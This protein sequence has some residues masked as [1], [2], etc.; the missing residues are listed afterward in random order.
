MRNHTCLLDHRQKI[1]SRHDW[2]RGD[3]QLGSIVDQQPEGKVVRQSR[4]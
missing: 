4:G 3:V 1:S 2:T